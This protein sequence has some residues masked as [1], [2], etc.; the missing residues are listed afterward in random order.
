MTWV[1]VVVC[2]GGWGWGGRM[3]VAGLPEPQADHT[4][5][6]A[7]FAMEAVRCPTHTHTRTLSTHTL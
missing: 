1:M 2:G 6:I 5:R 7:I 4:K 3:G